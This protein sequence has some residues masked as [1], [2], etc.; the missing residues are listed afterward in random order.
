M[1]SSLFNYIVDIHDEGSINATIK[2][3]KEHAVFKGHFPEFPVLPGVCQIL[4]IKEVLN[5]QLNKKYELRKAKSVKFLSILNP[6]ETESM[7]LTILYKID[8]EFVIKVD[9]ILFNEGIN[10]LKLKGEFYES[11]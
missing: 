9:A 11:K 8:A 2:I 3:N 5:G 7:K 1:L 10:Y 4:M 6:N